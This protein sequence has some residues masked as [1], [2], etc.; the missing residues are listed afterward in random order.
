MADPTV[1]QDNTNTQGSNS[2]NPKS[3]IEPGQFVVAGQDDVFKQPPSSPIPQSPP[4]PPESSPPGPILSK[5]PPLPMPPQPPVPES[6]QTRPESQP[7]QIAPDQPN[8]SPYVPPTTTTPTQQEP[9]SM[10][11]KL[12]KIAIILVMLI[13]LASAAAAVWFFVLG[14]NRAQTPQSQGETVVEVSPSPLPKRTTGGFA[15]LPAATQES[16]ASPSAQEGQ[17]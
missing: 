9:P 14:K 8:P 17:D 3:P 1:P 2:P 10:I 7:S 16:Q 15:D 4:P 13:V 11:Q 12:R 5:V 6:S